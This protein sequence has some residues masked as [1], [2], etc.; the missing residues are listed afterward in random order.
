MFE[1]GVACFFVGNLDCV[2]R[3]VNYGSPIKRE[4]NV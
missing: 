3:C 2:V 4:V 1:F